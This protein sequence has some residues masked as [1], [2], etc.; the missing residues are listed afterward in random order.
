M[1]A[2]VEMQLVSEPADAAELPIHFTTTPHTVV[3]WGT[4]ATEAEVDGVVVRNQSGQIR[5]N[6][7][8]EG[9]GTYPVTMIT[10]KGTAGERIA[11]RLVVVDTSAD[12]ESPRAVAFSPDGDQVG[13]TI[14]FRILA[15]G[16]TVG[17][18]EIEIRGSSGD[19]IRKWAAP[20][21]GESTFI[22][23]GKDLKGNPVPAGTY[24]VV[25]R[26]TGDS[27]TLKRMTQTV[28]LQR[29]GERIAAG[30]GW[31]GGTDDRGR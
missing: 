29:A 27:Q 10:G 26:T 13:D 7:R 17:A 24:T 5:A 20:G 6:K 19:I 18:R 30:D 23:D 25:Y 3:S 11:C 12:P 2:P 14:A 28:I 22:W 16:S 1:R 9:D 31:R 21:S 15:E 8:F 4:T